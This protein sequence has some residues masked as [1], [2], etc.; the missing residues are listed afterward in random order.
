MHVENFETNPKSKK[1]Q[2]SLDEYQKISKTLEAIVAAEN[3]IKQEQQSIS[4]SSSS[5]NR[6][7]Q[8]FDLEQNNF[9]PS[10][11]NVIINNTENNSKLFLF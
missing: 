5:N 6:M 3:K 4:S 9:S 1:Y 7:K 11:T 8:E 10:S 2:E